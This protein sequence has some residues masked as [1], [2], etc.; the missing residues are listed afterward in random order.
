M[1]DP[2]PSTDVKIK[3]LD[4]TSLV[5]S[6]THATFFGNGTINGTPMTYRI[7]VDDLREPG[8]GYDTFRIQTSTG[9]ILGG[10]LT[11]GNIQIH[12]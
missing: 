12:K 10:T 6:G 11:Q 3:C 7:D 5:R 9:F 2:H 4:V 8:S 1:V